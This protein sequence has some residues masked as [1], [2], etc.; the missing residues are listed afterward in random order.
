MPKSPQKDKEASRKSTSM[1][2]TAALCEGSAP[3]GTR[4]YNR[5][6]T[7]SHAPVSRFDKGLKRAPS[8]CT[9]AAL[10]L[11]PPGWRPKSQLRRAGD[12]S[13]TEGTSGDRIAHRPHRCRR[14]H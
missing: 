1:Q 4:N 10:V 7:P 8:R 12:R 13:A 3:R 14:S 6:W 5:I 11:L 2:F 9:P